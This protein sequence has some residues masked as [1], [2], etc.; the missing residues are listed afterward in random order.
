MKHW[1]M[2]LKGPGPH[3]IVKSP[4]LKGP[5]QDYPVQLL[6]LHSTTQNPNPMSQ[7]SVQMSLELHHLGLGADPVPNPQLPLP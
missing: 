4:K 5:H 1:H 7:S 2:G 3:R 6:V